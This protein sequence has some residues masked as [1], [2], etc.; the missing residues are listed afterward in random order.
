VKLATSVPYLL[1]ATLLVGLA[2][3]W[4]GGRRQIRAGLPLGRVVAID[5]LHLTGVE[6][7]LYD[8]VLDLTGRPDYLVRTGRQVIPVEVKSGRAHA[9]PLPGHVL[10]LAVYC[11]LVHAQTS[12]RP[13][14]GILRYADRAFAIDYTE[15]LE[16]EL[17]ETL[18]AMRSFES[19]A[20]PRSHESPARCRACGVRHACDQRLA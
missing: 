6:E 7:P 11:R 1:L 13:P 14:Y 15:T 17:L 10:Q 19:Q 5:T 3:V 8:P 12:R 4:L 16:Q 20:P 9:G 2:L 18:E